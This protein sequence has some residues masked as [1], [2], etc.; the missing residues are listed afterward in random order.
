MGA[1]GKKKKK[2]QVPDLWA[3]PNCLHAFQSYYCACSTARFAFEQTANIILTPS[4]NELRKPGYNFHRQILAKW[5]HTTKS[6]ICLYGRK[7][8]ANGYSVLKLDINHVRIA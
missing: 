8:T 7:K 2:K 6:V 1:K 3:A 4:L 5:D